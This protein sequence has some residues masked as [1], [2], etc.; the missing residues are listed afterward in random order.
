MSFAARAG[1][2][3]DRND[4]LIGSTDMG[5]IHIELFTTLDLAPV[6]YP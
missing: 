3:P 1:L 6:S 4:P 5:L 2:H